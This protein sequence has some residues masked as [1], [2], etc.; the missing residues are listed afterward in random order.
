[1]CLKDSRIITYG[2]S[3]FDWVLLGFLETNHPSNQSHT[4][5]SFSH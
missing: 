4:T 5:T 2:G 1:M 3:G